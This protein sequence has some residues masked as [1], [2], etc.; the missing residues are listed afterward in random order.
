MVITQWKTNAILFI[1][2]VA[3]SLLTYNTNKKQKK[4]IQLPLSHISPQ[5]VNQIQ[6][7]KN[8]EST[9]LHKKKNI[10]QITQ[11][12]SVKA[13]QFRIG[14]L[15][16]L[17]TTNNYTKYDSA[18]LKLK[19]FGL[20]TP[21]PVVKIN[22]EIFSF[23]ISNPINNKRYVLHNNTVYIIDDNFYP[24]INSQIGTLV[25]QNL[26]PT[27]T[28]LSS[29]QTNQFNLSKN[30]KGLWKSSLPASAD[31][32]NE[33]IHNWNNAQAFGVHDYTPTNKKP[34][35][36]IKV[37]LQDQTKP[38]DFFI[39]ST[40]PWLIIVRPDLNLEY[41]FDAEMY[42]RLFKLTDPSIPPNKRD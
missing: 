1:L 18:N 24:L 30:E 23:G 19:T 5:N 40:Q 36:N 11:P 31:S 10:W 13:N 2:V 32:I 6:I 9:V 14:S 33:M 41:H 27:E 8:G 42:D 17:L 3:L 35:N 37:V 38:I 28:I 25:D 34:L 4:P 26:F 39:K 21:S 16:Q 12:I 22:D 29:L 7:F 20:D 15:L